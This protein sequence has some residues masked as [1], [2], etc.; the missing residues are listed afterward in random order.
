MPKGLLLKGPSNVKVAWRTRH[1]LVLSGHLFRMKL[2]SSSVEPT[3]TARRGRSVPLQVQSSCDSA[4]LSSFTSTLRVYWLNSSTLGYDAVH[5]TGIALRE[6]VQDPVNAAVIIAM[7]TTGQ[8]GNE[9]NEADICD[10]ALINNQKSL[11][12]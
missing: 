9:C 11:E 10:M 4:L 1:E 2:G 12:H 8:W 6:I 7:P 3:S 5:Q